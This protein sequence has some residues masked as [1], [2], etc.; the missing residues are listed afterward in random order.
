MVSS[1]AAYVRVSTDSQEKR[2]TIASQV[3]ELLERAKADGFELTAADVYADDGVSGSTLVRPALERLRDQVFEGQVDVLYVLSPDRL[4]RKYAYQVL[5]LDEFARQGTEVRFVHGPAGDSPEDELLLQVQGIISEYERT[6]ILER[7]RRGKL[8][9]ARSGR[10]SVLSAAPYGYRYLKGVDGQP[11]EYQVDLAAART[12]R[13]VFDEFVHEKRSIRSIAIGLTAD[14]IPTATGLPTWRTSTLSKLLRNP[15]YKGLAAYGKT[16]TTARTALR[17][18]R[19]KPRVPHKPNNSYR[20]QEPETWTSIP[21]PPLVSEAVFE[22]AQER[23]APNQLHPRRGRAYLL[24]GLTVC[25]RCGYAVWGVSINVR[26]G[27]KYYRCSGT[28]ARRFGGQAVCSLPGIRVEALESH[29]WESV[30]ATVEHP[31]RVAQEWSRR[32]EENGQSEPAR[33]QAE[34]TERAVKGRRRVLERLQ[35]AYEVGALTL[36]ELTERVGRARERLRAAEQERD[37]ALATLEASR[38]IRLMTGQL[39]RFSEQVRGGLEALDWAGRQRLIRLLVDR[40]EL[41]D[42]D[43]TIVYRIPPTSLPS[44]PTAAR[45]DSRATPSQDFMGSVAGV[46]TP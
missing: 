15:A 36:D 35:D 37:R 10:V 44:D 9:A 4:A 16:K 5:L 28:E 34:E 29:V 3:E 40:I 31:E 43:V 11:A 39:E 7:S 8:H 13:R 45:E 26:R 12:V 21:V 25:A 33:R 2:G 30:V 18:A 24:Q 38:E 27:Y 46:N 1:I 22:A 6:K 14:G 23:L 42:A 17:P 41:G 20:W 32:G 19:G